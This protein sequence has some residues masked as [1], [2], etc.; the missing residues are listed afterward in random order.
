MI[1]LLNKKFLNI[2][3]NFY[4]LYNFDKGLFIICIDGIVNPIV[5]ISHLLNI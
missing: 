4:T 2:Y 3:Q 1:L 5:S